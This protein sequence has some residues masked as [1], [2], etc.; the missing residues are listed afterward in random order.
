MAFEKA[1]KYLDE[2]GY[3]DRVQ[4]F[5]VSSATVELA[6]V[7]VG[8]EAAR[9]CKSLTFK[10]DGKPVMVLFAGD[11]KVSNSK[12]KA[13]FRTKATM[14][15]REEVTEFIGHDVGGVCPF[16]INDGV[17]VYMDESLRRFDIV[18]PACGDAASAVKLRVEELETL[19]GAAGWVDVSNIP[20]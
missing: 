11:A 2:K 19:S 16:G 15:S 12:F 3:G 17:D 10:V 7:A 5:T 6:A 9:I 1:K 14:L 4:T 20:E 13:K 8:T 18:Y